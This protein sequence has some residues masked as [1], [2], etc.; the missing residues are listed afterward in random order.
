MLKAPKTGSCRVTGGIFRDRMNVNRSY[1]MELKS[2]SLL[3]NFYLEAGLI[4]PGLQVISEPEKAGLHWGWESPAC[5]LRGHFLGHWMS[6]AAMLSA[7]DGDVEI[8]AKLSDI[9]DELERCQQ[10]NGGKWVGSIPEKYF[11]FMAGEDYIWSPQYTMHKTLMGLVDAYRYAGIEKAL[12][13]ADNLADWYLEWTRS[14]KK[15]TP[16]AVFKGEQ[17]GMLEEWCILFGLT[18]DPK[19]KEL[20]DA[21]TE[22]GLYH[23]LEQ[24][25][26]PLTDDHANASI[27]LSH[28]AAA[29]YELYG[30]DR[31]K[32]ISERFW[33]WA[34][35]K[36]GMYATTGANSGEFWVPPHRQGS[37]LSDVD[38]EFCT[39]YN[40]VRLADFLYRRTGDTKYADYI[41]RALYNGFLAQQNMHSGMPAYYLPLK[42]GSRKKWGSKRHD[43]WCCHGTMVQAQTLYPR[44]I[45]YTDENSVT[46]AQY[47]PSE[48]EVEI[49]GKKVRLRQ[50]TELKNLNN[51]VFFD[52]NEGGEKTRW[53]IKI[54]ISCDEPT[55]F[56]LKL[57]VPKWIKDGPVLAIDGENIAPKIAD[58]YIIISR[59]WENSTI[60]LLLQPRLYTENLAD[61]PEM[62]ALLEGPIVL[63]G[64]TENDIG[65]V[66]D[67]AEP[68]SFL[69]HR[70]TH[71]YSTYVWKQSNYVTRRQP[72]NIEFKPLYEIKD[73][74]YTVYFT[75]KNKSN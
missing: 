55:E 50:A 12:T 13:I 58:N 23:Q 1:L 65:L 3:Q 47:I 66:G 46:L 25:K 49:G 4:M 39:V 37:Y 64:L 2:L 71:E 8:R 67:M 29:M 56:A 52:E 5:Q 72:V 36:R 26:D 30:D 74:V 57:R 19:Y 38:Q 40:M 27:P 43:F 44:L 17:G 63:A 15:T 28:G 21:Y 31:W 68:E 20:M 18:G 54:E 7:S 48:A 11:T 70:T 42:S 6:A 10:R 34:V 24:D 60:Q 22:N 14:I 32:V 41:E 51:Q 69:Q 45:W 73:E 75:D 59:L 9:V 62:T 53:S 35:D 16:F 33:E 61:M